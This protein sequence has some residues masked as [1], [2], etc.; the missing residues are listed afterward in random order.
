[1]NVYVYSVSG[2]ECTAVK[3]FLCLNNCICLQ[4]MISHFDSSLVVVLTAMQTKICLKSN[5]LDFTSP[6]KLSV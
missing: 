4:L 5:S 2:L 6:V 1:M 3:T